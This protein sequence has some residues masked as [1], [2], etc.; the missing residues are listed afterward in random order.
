MARGSAAPSTSWL[1]LLVL[2]PYPK[3]SPQ[4]RPKCPCGLSV[5]R[6]WRQLSWPR[7]AQRQ[8][9]PLR[10]TLLQQQR[11]PLPCHEQPPPGDPIHASTPRLTLRK[12]GLGRKRVAKNCESQRHLSPSWHQFMATLAVKRAITVTWSRHVNSLVWQKRLT[13]WPPAAPPAAPAWPPATAP[14]PA[15]PGRRPPPES[16]TASQG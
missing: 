9:R 15:A 4:R 6:L 3:P 2:P 16:A 1:R 11:N 8:R 12:N 5:Q 7:P 13:S 10:G 14:P